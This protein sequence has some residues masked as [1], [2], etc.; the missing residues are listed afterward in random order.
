VCSIIRSVFG[1]TNQQ[2]SMDLTL[3]KQVIVGLIFDSKLSRTREAYISL[4]GSME[5]FRLELRPWV[6]AHNKVGW[7][8]DVHSIIFNQYGDE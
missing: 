2:S 5:A 7:M 1:D 6:L 8:L 3:I 4:S